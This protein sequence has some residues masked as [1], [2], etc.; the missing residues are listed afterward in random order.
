MAISLQQVIRSISCLALGW[1]FRG[2]QTERHYFRFDQIQDA[3]KIQIVISLQ[4]I[5]RFTPCLTV[6]WVFRGRRIE[7]RCF[8]LDQIQ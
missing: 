3:W 2:R 1:G 7:W 6:G 8:Q 5:I 4:Q